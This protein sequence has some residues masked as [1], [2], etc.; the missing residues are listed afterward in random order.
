MA[1]VYSV[2]RHVAKR[3]VVAFGVVPGDEAGDL[4]L[5]VA[6]CFPDDEA[7]PVSA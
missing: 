6:R 1:V 3:L 2:R 4:G 7:Y 5:Q